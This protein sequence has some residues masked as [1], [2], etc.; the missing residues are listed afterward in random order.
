MKESNSLV[1]V[2]VPCYN[3]SQ[4]IAETIASVLNQTYP[5]FE[6]I[7]VNDGSSDNSVEVIDQFKDERISLINKKNSGVSDSRNVGLN[8][9]KGEFII[10][11]DADDLIQNDFLE[12]SVRIF[13][14]NPQTDFLTTEI[15]FIDKNSNEIKSTNELRGTYKNVQFEI[16]SFQLNISTCPSAYIYRKS[17]L[18]ENN[19]FFNS[20]LSSPSDRYY[21][22]QVGATLRGDLIP[23]NKLKYRVH[24]NSMSQ[25]KNKNLVVD[26]E[27]YFHHTMKNDIIVSKKDKRIFSRK[28]N[29]QLFVDYLKMKHFGKAFKYAG[30]YILT[31]VF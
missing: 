26:Q 28:L 20:F 15:D 5:T 12:K 18:I 19:I 1:S 22:L 16:A 8:V 7:I 30:K 27:K 24:A 23:E 21:L 11:L 17:K 13:K 9:A 6:L 29:Y 25:L 31:V 10:F 4:F 3:G 2:I 14:N